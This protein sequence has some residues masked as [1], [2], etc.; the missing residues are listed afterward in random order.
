[1]DDGPLKPFTYDAQYG[2]VRRSPA[3]AASYTLAP[4]VT[5]DRS[6]PT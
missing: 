3:M 5:T 6:N 2:R 1:M 4:L